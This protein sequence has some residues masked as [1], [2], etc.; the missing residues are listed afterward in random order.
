VNADDLIAKHKDLFTKKG[1]PCSVS[2]SKDRELIEALI[3]RGL[4]L[5]TVSRILRAEKIPVGY[6]SLRHHFTGECS[7]PR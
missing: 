7:C 2:T 1:P 3:S 4:N 6:N 5:A